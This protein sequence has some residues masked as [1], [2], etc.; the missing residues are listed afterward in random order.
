MV[1]ERKS[2][3]SQEILKDLIQG[4]PIST[5]IKRIRY[6]DGIKIDKRFKRKPK[7]A[8]KVK[9]ELEMEKSLE[10]A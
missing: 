10:S 6:R 1:E 5:Q 7:V 2:N 4:N 3:I 9:T 8:I